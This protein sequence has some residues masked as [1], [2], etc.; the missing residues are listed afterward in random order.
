MASCSP[1]L[2][3][4]APV[5]R[6][7]SRPDQLFALFSKG[8]SHAGKAGLGLYFC[9]ITVERWGGAI[10]AETRER[11]GSRFW[12]RLPRAGQT[13]ESK[14]TAAGREKSVEHVE[15]EKPHKN[16]KAEKSLRILVA[17]DA[18]LNR[19]LI[20]ELLKKRGHFAEGVAD[21]RQ[22]LAALEKHDFDVVLLD[23]EMP[24]MTG[25]Q[26]TAAI[27]RAR[28]HH[29]ETSDHHRHLRPRHRRR[30]T[31]I[32]RSWHGR[33]SGETR[34]SETLY[35]A[36]ESA[37]QSLHRIAGILGA[38]GR[39]C[40]CG[41]AIRSATHGRQLRRGLPS[42]FSC[43]FRRCRHA[44]ASHHWR[45]RKTDSFACRDISSRCSESAC[46][47][48]RRDREE[49]CRGT[50]RRC[51]SAER[52]ARHFWCAESRRRRAQSRS[53]GPRGQLA[54]SLRRIA[55]PRIRIRT[56]AAGT[57]RDKPLAATKNH[58]ATQA[59]GRSQAQT[60]T[61]VARFCSALAA[62]FAAS[63]AQHNSC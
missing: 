31:P 45:K 47:N 62:P 32:S 1:S 23:E 48:P 4:K 55:R 35:K 57:S 56:P 49:E 50:R 43:G 21:G 60:R 5:C 41:R 22:A 34:G 44:L 59:K 24:S 53:S 54:R 19:D 29:R 36:V 61:L 27:R 51:T 30:R 13:A 26:T 52:L 10:G 6:R 12:F 20:I 16:Q 38:R 3:M 25:L 39:I 42:E 9:K 40:C 37:A 15:K 58:I 46:A 17:D 2:T 63:L 18:E 11:G 14:A 28:S 8:K 7:I 33:I